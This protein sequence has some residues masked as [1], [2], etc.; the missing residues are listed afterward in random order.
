M[1]TFLTVLA[2]I[3][4]A[5][6]ATTGVVVAASDN[7]ADKPATSVTRTVNGGSLDS[8]TLSYDTGQ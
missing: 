3:V 8:A 7:P 5:G 6:A 4:L 1:E 2:G